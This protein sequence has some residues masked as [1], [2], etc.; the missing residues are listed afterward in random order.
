[1]GRV[2]AIADSRL[3]KCFRSGIANGRMRSLPVLPVI[4]A[5]DNTDF[6]PFQV[7]RLPIERSDIC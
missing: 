6:A 5:G 1:M 4:L 7:N 3:S 2:P